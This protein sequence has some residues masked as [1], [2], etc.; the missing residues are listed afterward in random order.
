MFETFTLRHRITYG[1]IHQLLR[2]LGFIEHR[3]TLP[4]RAECQVFPWSGSD[5]TVNLA[6]HKPRELASSTDVGSVRRMLDLR[7]ILTIDDF[8]EWMDQ[9]DHEHT[10]TKT[11]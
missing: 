6:V 7:Q 9:A 3:I 5:F 8:D 2:D 10:T 11:G 1:Q 4:H